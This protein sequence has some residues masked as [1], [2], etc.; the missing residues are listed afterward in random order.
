M[1]LLIKNGRIINPATNTD[2]VADVLITDSRITQIGEIDD[3][4]HIDEIIDANGLWVVPGLIDVHVHFRQPGYE[5][6]ETI[7]TGAKS[8]AKGGFTTVCIMPN[9]NP[10]IDNDMLVE[11]IKLLA[12]KE[13]IVNVL[14]IGAI[15]IGQKGNTLTDINKMKEA[16]IC[17]ISEDGRSVLNANLLKN[18][19]LEAK[20]NNLPVLSHCEDES[21]AIGGCM[22]EGALA[23]KLGV[24][25]IPNES[26]EIIVLRDIFLAQ[27]TK[28][29][30]H[31]C[32]VS[33]EGSVKIIKDA[34]EKGIMVTAEATPHHF[35][36]TEEAVI[37]HEGNA[38]MNPPLR[39]EADVIAIKNALKDGN[40]DIIATD[41][42]P[43]H[44]DEK[45]CGLKKA[46]NGI[47]GLETSVPL[48][49]SEL[50]SKGFLTP[51]GMVEKMSYNPAKMLGIDKGNLD[52]GK[53]AD[54]TIID[55]DKEYVINVN[56]FASKSKNSPFDKRKVKGQIMYTIVNGNIQYKYI[57]VDTTKTKV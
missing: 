49:I 5:Y 10:V 48:T 6:K 34:K 1:K 27:R 47:V 24:K 53:I 44:M 19:M 25:G 4:E 56:E 51:L 46:A 41:H 42:A 13:A 38:K 31:I 11:D 8:A 45:N 35:T 40:I 7:E 15:T 28:V 17:A 37:E 43:H 14:P 9:T 26:E 55:P 52:I 3:S 16:G 23:D 20:N 39:T 36:L 22:N 18:A 33:T 29:K 50:V 12:E 57:E 2:K 30:L 54:I 21:L 32:H